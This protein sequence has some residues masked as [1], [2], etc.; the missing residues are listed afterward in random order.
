MWESKDSIII[1]WYCLCLCFKRC[2][3]KWAFIKNRKYKSKKHSKKKGN[4]V[5][6]KIKLK[7]IIYK[8]IYKMNTHLTLHL[9]FFGR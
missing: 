2:K 9:L 3:A 7:L 1:P 8:I 5:K 4:K 6:L